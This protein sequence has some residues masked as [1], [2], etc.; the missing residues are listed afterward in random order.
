MDFLK[1][2]LE[3]AIKHNLQDVIVDVLNLVQKVKEAA[4]T[5]PEIL[6]DG[7]MEEL[8]TIHE[9]ALAASARLDKVLDEQIDKQS[10]SKA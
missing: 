2:L 3:F 7:S 4:K 1:K 6:K 9:E 8:D 10:T 5:V